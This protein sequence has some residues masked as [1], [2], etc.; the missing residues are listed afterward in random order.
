MATRQTN[1]FGGKAMSLPYRTSE[2]HPITSRI[3]EFHKT[4]KAQFD[5]HYALEIGM[6]LKGRVER[7]CGDWHAMLSPGH[8]WLC[9]IWEPHGVEIAHV[10]TQVLVLLAHPPMLAGVRFADQPRFSFMSPFL[11]APRQR[12]VVADQRAGEFLALAPRY[13]ETIASKSPM[14]SLRLRTILMEMLLM[15]MEGWQPPETTA[16]QDSSYH[17]ITPAMDL[18]FA[19]SNRVSLEQAAAVC[20]MSVRAFSRLFQDTVGLSFSQFA[21]R[22]RL[23][24]AADRLATTDKAIKTIAFELGFASDSHLCRLFQQHYDCSPAMYRNR[25]AMKA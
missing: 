19:S 22:H 17:E 13:L 15:L 18:V 9:G 3:Y 23:H 24:T 6:V 11:A 16:G 8:V 14:A 2:E 10:P 20:R 25:R 1:V 21:V 12:P 4:A 7:H 5:M